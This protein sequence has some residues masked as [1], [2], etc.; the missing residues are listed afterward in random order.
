MKRRLLRSRSFSVALA[1]A[2]VCSPCLAAQITVQADKPGAPI[3]PVMW[4]VFFE[5]INFGAD[6][7]LYA[8]LVK[9]RSFEFPEPWTGWIRI[10][11]SN[12]KGEAT[13]VEEGPPHP[14]DKRFLRLRSE[15]ST[16]FGVS[17]EGF[18]GIGVRAGENYQFSAQIRQPSGSR[19][20]LLVEIVAADGTVLASTRLRN[21]TDHWEEYSATLQPNAT[22][23]KARLN[24]L[25][26]GPGTLDL[27][28]ISLFPEKT[29]KNRPRGLRADM[30][31][32]LADLKPGFFRFPGGCIVEGSDLEKRY[33]W[34]KTIGPI[35][36]REM[37]IN[38]WNYEFRHRPTPDYFQSFGLGF[39]EYFQLSEDI[40]AEPLPILN[41]GMACQF[42]SGQLVPMS[43]LDPFIQD[44]LDL[45]E[46]ANGPVT[47]TWGAKRAEMGHPEPFNMKYLGI[48]NE[49]WGPQYIERYAAFHRVLKE[50]HPEIH[51]V[52][53][54]GPSPADDRFHFLVPRLRELKADI[55]DEH[56]YAN[57]IWFFHN[58]A[59]YDRY[60]RNG[61]KIFMG[62]YAAQS[63]AI[64]SPKNRNTLECAL[65]EAALMTG[66]ERNADVVTMASYAPLF[67]HVDAWQWTPNLIWVDNLRVYGTPNYYVQQ[68][69]S[70]N[71]GDAVLPV[72][73]SGV[74]AKASAPA[75]QIG[76][77]T[78]QTA[79]EFRD[80]R[81]ARGN[82]VLLQSDFAQ[83]AE[84]WSGDNRWI[85]RDGAYVQP[86]PRRTSR[87][88]A[89]NTGWSDYTLSLKARKIAGA[90]GFM[91]LVR[92]RGPEDYILWNAGGYGNTA[93]ALVWRFAQQDHQ[94][95]RVE[96][97][98]DANRS[99]DVQVR[100]NG[101]RVECL[102][103][104]KAVLSADVPAPAVQ[105]LYASAARDQQAGEVVL[106]V[107]NPA[108]T[109][110]TVDL[111]IAGRPAGG[112]AK[113]IVLTGPTLDAVNS[114]DA[115]RHVAPVESTV[116]V[117]GARFRHE[118][119]ARS[120]T[121]L[122]IPVR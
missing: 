67:G 57:P 9:N 44:A 16:P 55:L 3:S 56:C 115:P 103:D 120:L 53:A 73:I 37:L 109:A 7:G 38:R 95:A 41:C 94:I 75:G 30:V 63:V 46:F 99:Y 48:G 49:Q 90:E 68:L 11:P 92:Y 60:D 89:G 77:G 54:A 26:D 51:L 96:G 29:W 5:D 15:A 2:A 19:A 66:M 13:L 122:R 69:F 24:V 59:R 17:N 106:K 23:P 47:S 22:E 111:N 116:Q 40:G 61:P 102:L 81:V 76:L 80:V 119:P 87:V 88:F 113:A 65:A 110:T 18:R 33:Q 21:F 62:E 27:D 105:P 114:L 32:M 43:E 101:T 112:T 72:E 25:L 118:F 83:N 10:S 36:D 4:G 39:F 1:L 107:V 71:R 85:V 34:K 14:A 93:H 104:G 117:S 98:I 52:A 70:L 78:Y 82:E 50:K 84:G 64:A 42:N 45:I 121:V 86:D 28:F 20:T 97:S 6:G 91:V 108:E 8:E 12:A 58:A 35:I 31:Q 100:L 79:A 74:P